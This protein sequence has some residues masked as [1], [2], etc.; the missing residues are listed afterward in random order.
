MESIFGDLGKPL[1]LGNKIVLTINKDIIRNK[2]LEEILKVADPSI[3]DK[4]NIKVT[5]DII[6]EV[7]L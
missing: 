5:G 4:I 7:T 2:I 3:K 1:L 6:V